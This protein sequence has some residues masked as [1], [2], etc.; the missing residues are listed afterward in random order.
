[1]LLF[2]P[3]QG[4]T[5]GPLLWLLC[6]FL[7]Y[8]SLDKKVSKI[9]LTAVDNTT[10]V[11]YVGEAFVDDTG[12]GTNDITSENKADEHTAAIQNLQPLAQEWEKLLFS[13]GGAQNLQK[14]FGFSCPGDGEK[15]RHTYIPKQHAPGIYNLPQ[16]QIQH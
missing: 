2:G 1:M 5:I 8:L 10:K 6:F 15:E 13:T 12:L 4:S 14:C 16:R 7:I 11:E 9:K 3:G